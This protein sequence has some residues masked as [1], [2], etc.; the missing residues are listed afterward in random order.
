LYAPHAGSLPDSARGQEGH[1]LPN[2]W[3]TA[4]G[5]RN[6]RKNGDRIESIPSDSVCTTPRQGIPPPSVQH[7]SGCSAK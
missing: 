4:I 5:R 7:C 2:L 1:S 6:L 3:M